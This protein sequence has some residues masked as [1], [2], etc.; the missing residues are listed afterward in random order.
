FPHV[1]LCDTALRLTAAG[2]FVH[3]SQIPGP[4]GL[5]QASAGHPAPASTLEEP[6][7][8]DAGSANGRHL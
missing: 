4:H 5:A 2:A 3:T 8:T 6:L 7:L 1:A